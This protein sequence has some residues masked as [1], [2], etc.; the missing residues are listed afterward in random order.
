MREMLI[1]RYGKWLPEDPQVIRAWLAK[2]IEEV[3]LR[4]RT[5]HLVIEEFKELIEGDAQIYLLFHQMFTEVPRKWPYIQDPTGQPQVRDYK[6]MLKLFNHIMTCAPE[7]G[8]KSLVGF[9][10]NAV[11]DWPMGSGSGFA[12]LLNYK[13]NS[14]FRKMLNHNDPEK[15]WFGK[16]AAA[17]MPDFDKLYICDPATPHHGF[18]SWDGFFTRQF[19]SGVRPVAASEEDS[20]VVN[21]CESAPYRLAKNVKA[22]DRFWVKAQPYSL[23]HMLAGDVFASQFIGGIV[24]Q[25]FLSALS[26]HRWHSP[27]SGRVVKAY[28]QP[29]TYYSESIAEGFSKPDSAAPNNSQG[30]IT[31]VATR[32]IIFIEA[33]DPN[34]G[35]MCVMPVGMAE[36]STCD[37]TVYEGQHVRKGDQLGMFHFGGSTH[38]LLFRPEV[39]IKFNLHGQA[40]GPNAKN[41]NVNDVIALVLEPNRCLPLR[42]SAEI[43]SG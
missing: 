16:A 11:L 38:C 10:I 39:N 12:A 25:A 27:V 13:V 24:Y 15:G 9:P 18:V 4:D 6:M 8:E 14:Q 43:E 34:I 41:I 17:A 26:Y 30:Y 36:V 23:E 1:P 31:A 20:V 33:D 32:A 2:S 28:V 35:L 42:E 3:S 22:H 29:G 7:F 21:A 40:P 37:I 19:R 5:L